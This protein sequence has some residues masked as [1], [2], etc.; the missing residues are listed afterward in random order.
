MCAD[1]DE[2]G[3]DLL[4][5]VKNKEML[6]VDD[7]GYIK[8]PMAPGLGIEVDEAA[9]RKA[10]AAGHDWKDREWELDDGT[11]TTW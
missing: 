3:M 5:Y 6:D 11:P 1:N 4:D 8:T 2:G 7:E 9:V 10:A